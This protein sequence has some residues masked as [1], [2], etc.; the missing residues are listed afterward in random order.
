M[1]RCPQSRKP[2][3]VRYC[4]RRNLHEPQCTTRDKFKECATGPR[5]CHKVFSRELRRQA[6]LLLPWAPGGGL[7]PADRR[8]FC[9]DGLC[10][11][12]GQKP[13]GSEP[14]FSGGGWV[15]TR[16]RQDRKSNAHL[17]ESNVHKQLHSLLFFG[18]GL[19]LELY[20]L[21]PTDPLALCSFHGL[22]GDR[23]QHCVDSAF[24]PLHVFVKKFVE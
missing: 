6:I 18:H 13:N 17:F 21:G 20:V 24:G 12:R 11:A 4:V 19:P 3:F 1:A 9:N 8:C 23:R 22:V 5:L 15:L 16:A 14:N 2:P 7:A 10:I